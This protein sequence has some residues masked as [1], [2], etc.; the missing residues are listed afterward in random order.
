[1]VG[2]VTF[3]HYYIGLGEHRYHVFFRSLYFLPLVLAGFWFGLRGAVATS[4]A[5]TTAYLPLTIIQW[6]GFSAS[7]LSRITEVV[8]YNGVAVI[9]GVL[10]DREWREQNRSREAERLAAMGKAVSSV[11]HDMKTPLTAIGG[12]SRLVQK[13][14]KK[15]HPDREKLGIVIQ[16]TQRLEKLVEEM[17]DFSRP[18]VLHL[19][20]HEIDQ[21]IRDSLAVVENTAREQKVELQLRPSQDA[22]AV[23]MDSMRMK[24]VVINLVVN[25]IQASHEGASVTISTYRKGAKLFVDVIDYGCG[26]PPDK[27]DEVFNPFFTTKENGTGLGLPIVKKIV[28]AHHGSLEI[29]DN[30]DR[31]VTFRVILPLT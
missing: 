6:Q 15:D 13:H 23:T 20:K 30:P 17:L 14:I 21:V 3:L 2:G 10:R 24:Q 19:S 31:G 1:M 9:L 12:F 25:G 22:L 5:I 16:E 28:E 11:A 27:R 4:L 8:L 18:L 7:D 29:L 26:I